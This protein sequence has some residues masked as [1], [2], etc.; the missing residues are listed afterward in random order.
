MAGLLPERSKNRDKTIHRI[1]FKQ[2][3][4]RKFITVLKSVSPYDL[5]S[6]KKFIASPYFNVN[7]NITLFNHILIDHCVKTNSE[8]IADEDVW[9]LI[10]NDIP[11]DDLKMRRLYSDS[12]KLFQQFLS[13]EVFQ[14]DIYTQTLFK[15][16]KI[17][18]LKIDILQNDA[19]KET[20]RIINRIDSVSSDQFHNK[21]LLQ[22]D[23]Y[24]IR[25]GYD[26]KHKSYK[27]DIVAS[28]RKLEKDLDQFYIIEKLRIFSTII[29][30][31]RS[32]KTDIK[33]DRYKEFIDNTIDEY[34]HTSP[35][36]QMYINIF[37][38]LTAHNAH[39]RYLE[40]KQLIKKHKY[41]F[42]EEELKDLYEYAFSYSN[43]RLNKGDNSVLEEVFDLYKEALKDDVLLSDGELSPTTFKNIVVLGLR[44]GQLEWTKYF[45]SHYSEKISEK[46]RHNA[47]H[48]N[49][50]RY[51]FY[52]K[53]YWE[54]ISN[55]QQVNYD[56]IFYNL[57]SR[58]L[59]IACYYELEEL[60]VMESQIN[61]FLMF[62]RRNK[63]LSRDVKGNYKNYLKYVKKLSRINI[64]DKSKILEIKLELQ[65]KPGVVSKGWILDKLKELLK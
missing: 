3:K 40:L 36:I 28:M 38:L 31:S 23:L 35:A 26:K 7:E 41:S 4:E 21:F 43:I 58:I 19:Q 8:E 14:K 45:I 27:G 9:K 29:S 49:M 24:G 54:A 34:H 16:N 25:I 51:N 6:Y 62:I 56:D 44:C 63:T 17:N 42:K 57:D 39:D 13:N 2:M 15:I 20:E 22:R 18:D 61:S 30:W 52:M 10:F 64:N 5:N 55:L 1:N 53:D 50:A 11:Y 33:F 60:D 47:V 48:F 32:I 59:L 12:L 46:F 65:D 37:H